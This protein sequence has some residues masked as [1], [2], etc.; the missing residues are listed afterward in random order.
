MVKINFEILNREW[1]LR[2]LNRKKYTKK[3]GNDSVGI[4]Y[5]WKRR[6]DVGTGVTHE[7]L[8]HELVHAYLAEMCMGSMNEI[9]ISDMEEF[10]AELMSKRGRELLDLAD[11]L[12]EQIQRT[13]SAKITM[14]KK[15]D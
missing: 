9:S 6:I 2:V 12:L 7:D 8:C 11:N 1:T 5:G 13:L 4:T 10:Y 15:T 14:V 3:N